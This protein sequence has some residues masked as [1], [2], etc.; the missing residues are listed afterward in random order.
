MVVIYKILYKGIKRKERL[1]M[2]NVEASMILKE[3]REFR[4]ENNKR[5]KENDK[6]W[7]Q[8]EKRWEANDKK[9]EQNEKRWT[10]NDE[11]WRFTEKRLLNLEEAR[12]K[13]KQDLMNILD[14]MQK[15]IS[16]QFEEMKNYI[17]EKFEKIMALQIENEKEHL[18]FM[19]AI[20]IH[21]KRL[22]FQNSRVEVLENWKDEMENGA[23]FT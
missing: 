1:Q 3:L 14:T 16:N 7:E 12:Q 20:T 18:K 5:W 17:D 2:E 6:K 9:W 23:I 4:D 8:N 10:E 19:Q 13:D 11:K 15:S 21:E 22:N